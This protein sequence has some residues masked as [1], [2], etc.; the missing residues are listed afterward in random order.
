MHRHAW[1]SLLAISLSVS[2]CRSDPATTVTG[3]PPPPPP[4]PPL[5]DPLRKVI[6]DRS[7]AIGVGS[8]VGSLFNNATDP[9]AAQ[10]MT[11]L[12]REFNV[13]TPENDMKF[14]PLR[15]AQN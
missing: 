15:P 9:A 14:G 6:A 8:A 3:P 7:L 5:L 2:A 1:I 13:I 12:T 11:V 4:P 10:Y